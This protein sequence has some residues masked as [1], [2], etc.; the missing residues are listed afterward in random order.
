M[1]TSKNLAATYSHSRG[2][3]WLTSLV[4][5]SWFCNASSRM[6]PSLQHMSIYHVYLLRKS[7][8]L[9]YPP[10][11]F[12]TFADAYVFYRC[13]CKHKL[14]VSTTS[15]NWCRIMPVAQT[16]FAGRGLFAAKPL[17]AGAVVFSVQPMVAHPTVE[18]QHTVRTPRETL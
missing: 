2:I 4:V 1:R 7:V 12:P 10:C 3:C 8:Q 17:N 15:I 9:V 11:M 6:T 18:S 5:I 14:H 16:E 13:N